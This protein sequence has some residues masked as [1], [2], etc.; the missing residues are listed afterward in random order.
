MFSNTNMYSSMLLDFKRY[1]IPL[2]DILFILEM[3]SNTHMLFILE[4]FEF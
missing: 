1:F 4:Y 3:F 2:N